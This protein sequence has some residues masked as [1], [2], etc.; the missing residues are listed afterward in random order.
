MTRLSVRTLVV[1]GV[2]VA[3]VV[4][5]FASLY[6][7]GDPDGLNRVAAEEGLADQEQAHDLEDGP[8][9]G[10]EAS[11]IDESLSGGVAGVAGIAATFLLAGGLLLVVRRRGSD[12]DA[13]GPGAASSGP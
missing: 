2:I 5:A 9:A 11:G 13:D 6:A 4:A 3:V 8:F 10:Y 1:T 7:S 12:R